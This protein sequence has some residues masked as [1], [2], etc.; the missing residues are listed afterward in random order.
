MKCRETCGNETM[1]GEMNCLDKANQ[2]DVFG[3]RLFVLVSSVRC[4]IRFTERASFD[5]SEKS[6]QYSC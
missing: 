1:I 5:T 4:I 3:E 2:R 6:A